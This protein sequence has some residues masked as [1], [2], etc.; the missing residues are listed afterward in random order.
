MIDDEQTYVLIPQGSYATG[1]EREAV[2]RIRDG[3]GAPNVKKEFLYASCPVHTEEIRPVMVSKRL[4]SRAEF[5]LFASSA[6]YRSEAETD[7]WGWISLDGRWRKKEGVSWRRP[8]GGPA[9]ERYAADG[10]VP[11]M[12][13]SWNDAVAY[14]R[15]ISSVRGEEAR[16]PR[17]AEWEVFARVTGVP[18][19]GGSV[20]NTRTVTNQDEFIEAVIRAAGGE[21]SPPGLLWEWTDDWYDRYPGGGDHRDFG[22]VYKVLRGGSALSEPV[23]RS[24]EFRLRKCPT[25]RSPYYG[26]RIALVR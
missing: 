2:D 16:L 20:A 5:E 7:G 12:Q 23:Q 17:E 21:L 6:G 4:V 8:F 3:A 10:R 25:A 9:D 13:V 19:F 1:L 11:V 14:S 18:A 24:R 15:W 22:T 26:F